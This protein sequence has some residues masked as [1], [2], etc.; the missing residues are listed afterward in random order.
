MLALDLR[1]DAKGLFEEVTKRYPRSTAS[2]KA[3]ARLADLAT[4]KKKGSS[5]KRP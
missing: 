2:R 3:K 1:D 5:K 4:S